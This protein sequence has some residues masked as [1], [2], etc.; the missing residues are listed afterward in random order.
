MASITISGGSELK[1][2]GS[3]G[4]DVK[5]WVSHSIKFNVDKD[6]SFEGNVQAKEGTDV[7]PLARRH[8]RDVL[9]KLSNEATSCSVTKSKPITK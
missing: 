8:F 7:E 5:G 4:K 9:L 6:T 1:K 2:K 3:G